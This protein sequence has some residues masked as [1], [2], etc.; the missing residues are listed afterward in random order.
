VAN[1]AGARRYVLDHSL[2]SSPNGRSVPTI[3]LPTSRNC[4]LDKTPTSQY[5]LRAL[6]NAVN[7]LKVESSVVGAACRVCA[8]RRNRLKYLAQPLPDLR[9]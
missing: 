4:L 8:S 3:R 2:T 9:E 5:C 6:R 7:I 1:D